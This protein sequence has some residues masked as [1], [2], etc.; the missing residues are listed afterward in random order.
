MNQDKIWAYFQAG[1]AE[2]FAGANPR[3]RR[4]VQIAAKLLAGQQQVT[5]LNI[6][7]GNAFLEREC[8]NRNWKTASLDPDVAAIDKLK[9]LNVDAQAGY[10]EHMPFEDQTFD[11]VFSSEV[12]EHLSKSQ[13]D[14]GL[15]NIYRVLKD[16]RYLIGTVPYK[17][18]LKS[19]ETVCPH[20]G[21]TFHRWG[22]QST[23][24]E[25]RMRQIMAEHG[26]EVVQMG[27]YVFP[28][29][30]IKRPYYLLRSS[31]LWLLGRYGSQL[32]GPSLL[33]VGKKI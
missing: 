18:T 11:A 12:F 30:S 23:F 1:N 9:A 33:F 25:D 3:L 31:A 17:E 16:G 5:V 22:H 8:L 2:T 19:S 6:G 24:D 13:F 14:A 26:F 10:I 15:R 20:C 4:L 32:V 29:F 21:E 27:S 7:I 28:D